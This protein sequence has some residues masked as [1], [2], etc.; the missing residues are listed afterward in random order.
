MLLFK[1]PLRFTLPVQVQFSTLCG[2]YE[3]M[4]AAAERYHVPKFVGLPPVTG[5]VE[6]MMDVVRNTTAASAEVI[7]EQPFVTLSHSL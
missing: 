1:Q 4:A 5:S 6:Y 2:M 7:R 3:F